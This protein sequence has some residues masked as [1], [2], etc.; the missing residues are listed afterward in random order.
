MQRYRE[1][2][3]DKREIEVEG[4]YRERVK[5]RGIVRESERERH[6]ERE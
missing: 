3:R 1:E 2:G 4:I 6:R 5:G